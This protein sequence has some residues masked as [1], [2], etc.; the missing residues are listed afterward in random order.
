MVAGFIAAADNRTTNSTNTGQIG[1]LLQSTTYITGVSGGGWLVGSIYTN[2]FSSVQDLRDGSLNSPVWQFGNS[3]L[4]GPND[5]GVQ[6]LSSVDYWSTIE[7]EVSDKQDAG[8]NVSLTDYWGRALSYQLYEDSR[9]WKLDSCLNF[10]SEAALLWIDNRPCFLPLK[11]NCPTRKSYLYCH[12]IHITVDQ[13]PIVRIRVGQGT[14]VGS[15]VQKALISTQKHTVLS[16]S[17]LVGKVTPC[18]YFK[19]WQPVFAKCPLGKLQN[20]AS[21]II[22]SKTVCDSYCFS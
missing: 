7:S 18:K 8:F 3:I 6:L 11:V 22:P 15:P 17:T 9:Y 16:P 19:V 1:G 10:L 20:L 13:T 14:K 21:Q 12:H 4:E 5:D 2:N